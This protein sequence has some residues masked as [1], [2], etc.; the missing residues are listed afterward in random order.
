[1]INKRY[2][3]LG[4]AHVVME[5]SEFTGRDGKGAPIPKWV[6]KGCQPIIWPIFSETCSGMKRNELRVGAHPLVH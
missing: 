4:I 1:M 2:C 5:E 3:A 6:E